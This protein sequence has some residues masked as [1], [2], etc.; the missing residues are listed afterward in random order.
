MCKFCNENGIRRTR[1]RSRVVVVVF[2]ARVLQNTFNSIYR[3]CTPSASVVRV[4]ALRRDNN[5]ILSYSRCARESTCVI[6]FSVRSFVRSLLYTPPTLRL[7]MAGGGIRRNGA[8]GRMRSAIRWKTKALTCVC[9][10]V[11]TVQTRATMLLNFSYIL[12]A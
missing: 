10:A 2:E 9:T 6:F 7:I 4:S 1:F 3:R 11:C 5:K 8:A 12:C